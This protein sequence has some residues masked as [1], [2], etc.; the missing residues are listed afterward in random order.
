MTRS[1]ADKTAG[2]VEKFWL[3]KDP[4]WTM[5]TEAE[6]KKAF[7]NFQN[8]EKVKANKNGRNKI[9]TE[10]NQNVTVTSEDDLDDEE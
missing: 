4:S 3:K 6:I 9:S 5:P 10:E 2:Y 1:I 8:N 7:N